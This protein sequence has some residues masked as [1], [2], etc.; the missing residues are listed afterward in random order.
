MRVISK[1]EEL[2]YVRDVLDQKRS[3]YELVRFKD[4]QKSYQGATFKSKQYEE[5]FVLCHANL[6]YPAEWLVCPF[7]V[8]GLCPLGKGVIEID[9]KWAKRTSLDAIL[10]IMSATTATKCAL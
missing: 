10:V 8:S 9:T 7:V 1:D 2:K 5:Y 6:K 4:L 3:A